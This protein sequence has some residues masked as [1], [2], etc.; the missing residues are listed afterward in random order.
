MIHRPHSTVI[1]IVDL[2]GIS[3]TDIQYKLYRSFNDDRGWQRSRSHLSHESRSFSVNAIDKSFVSNME[4]LVGI[5][6]I[7]SHFIRQ[8]KI[9]VLISATA[10]FSLWIFFFG[11]VI[12]GQFV[13]QCCIAD[14]CLYYRFNYRFLL[15]FSAKMTPNGPK[16]TITVD[17][18]Q[19]LP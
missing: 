6:S 17:N 2:Y 13:R 8:E 3:Y 14:L 5:I 11:L 12:F 18:Y 15:Y 16:N 10:T 1:T 7:I 9:S 4:D 19:Y